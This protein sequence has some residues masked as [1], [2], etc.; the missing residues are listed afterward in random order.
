M[1]V[2]NFKCENNILLDCD[3]NLSSCFNC[4]NDE[5]D[6]CSRFPLNYIPFDELDNDVQ[7]LLSVYH[8]YKKIKGN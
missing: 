5:C 3:Y 6:F 4:V 1:L 2:D 8:E 7:D